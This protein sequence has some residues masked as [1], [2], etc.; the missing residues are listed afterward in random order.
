MLGRLVAC[1][2]DWGSLLAELAKQAGTGFLLR[3]GRKVAAATNLISSWAAYYT[4][5]TTIADAWRILHFRLRARARRRL[6][7]PPEPRATA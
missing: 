5:R 1:H 3:P 2:T 6:D 7:I 4:G